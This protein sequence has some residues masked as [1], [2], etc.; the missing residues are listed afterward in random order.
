MSFNSD[1]NGFLV[2]GTE[3]GWMRYFDC[4]LKELPFEIC[5]DHVFRSS[6]VEIVNDDYRGNEEW[7]EEKYTN[8]LEEELRSLANRW[9]LSNL[10][11]IGMEIYNRKQIE[12]GLTYFK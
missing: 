4:S 7:Y 1:I 6:I 9:A 12:S 3:N 10:E 2:L 5:K 8:C 11:Q